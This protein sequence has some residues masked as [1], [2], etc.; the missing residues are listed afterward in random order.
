[1]F[2]DAPT[3]STKCTLTT[4]SIERIPHY[5]QISY[6]PLHKGKRRLARGEVF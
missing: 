3:M 1:M 5:C 6:T 4:D 2:R